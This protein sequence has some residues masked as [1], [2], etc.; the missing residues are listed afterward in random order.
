[1]RIEDDYGRL[2]RH[3]VYPMSPDFIVTYLSG[4][5]ACHKLKTPQG[6]WEGRPKAGYFYEIQPALFK[7]KI[8]AC[9]VWKLWASE[10]WARSQKS[11][12]AE[13]ERYGDK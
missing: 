6:R 2:K 4:R 7:P 1:M 5:S 10:H 13:R 3:K 9:S 11:N 8:N 12:W